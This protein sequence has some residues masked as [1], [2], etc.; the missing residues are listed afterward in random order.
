[1]ECLLVT[2]NMLGKHQA[3]PAHYWWATSWGGGHQMKDGWEPDGRRYGDGTAEDSVEGYVR[4][5]LC[6]GRP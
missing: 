4:R 1:M 6:P 5:H 3:H 2:L